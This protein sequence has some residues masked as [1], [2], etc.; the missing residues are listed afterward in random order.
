MTLPTSSPDGNRNKTLVVFDSGTKLPLGLTA[1]NTTNANALH[2]AIVD[3][4]G[5][6]ITSFGGGTQY[7][8]GAAQA[9]PVGTVALGYD[10][11][12]VRALLTDSSGRLT[13]IPNSSVNVTQIG[14]ASLALGQGTKSA[15]LPVTIASDQGVLS[16]QGATANGTAV[17]GNPVLVGGFDGTNARDISV[18]TS[19]RVNG[20]LQ[21]VAGS[22]LAL[23]QTTMSASLPVAIASNQAAISLWGHG[24]T[25]ASVPANITY[26]G[27]Q[28]ITSLPTA[29]S[30]AQS[31]GISADKFGRQ[32]VLP[33]GMRDVILPM[34]Q[35]TLTSSTSETTLIAAVASTFLDILTLIV[36]NTSATATQVDF[37]DSTG[38]TIRASVYVP[39]GETRGVSF[40][41]ILPQN[42]V[43]NNWT[44][45]CGTSVASV[46]ITGTY[47]TNK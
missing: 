1:Q 9:S 28:A 26:Q 35:L 27:A 25:G 20:N 29:V 45:K 10:G 30:N 31:V 21:Q 5:T 32:I 8:A 38:G 24:A 18:D 6:Q 4:S 39:A 19:G 41:G 11:A 46:I 36:I 12:N 17:S 42:A 16:I 37:R 13:L 2:V 33:H 15:S 34:T 47:V 14:G 22:A 40:N 7:T 23:G 43:N 3:G 44:A